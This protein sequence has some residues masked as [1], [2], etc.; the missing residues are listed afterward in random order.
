MRVYL[1]NRNYLLRKPK[2]KKPIISKNKI[3]INNTKTKQKDYNSEYS[4]LVY[5]H[6]AEVINQINF[7]NK[8]IAD[9]TKIYKNN[10]TLKNRLINSLK[11]ECNASL[12]KIKQKY[13]MLMQNLKN[14]Y[15]NAAIADAAATANAATAVVSNIKKAL[16]IGINYN[17]TQY[18]LN[19][20]INDVENIKTHILQKGFKESNI[21]TL[22][23]DTQEKPNRDTILIKFQQ[24]LSS[25]NSGDIVLF[26]YSGHGSYIKDINN[27]EK[28]NNDETIVP[29]DFN[30][31]SDDTLK[32]IIDA[33]LKEGVTLIAFFDSCHSGTMLDLP[34]QYFD[35]ENNNNNTVNNA[36]S[37]TK[38][39]V[40]MISGC[41]D[42]QTSADAYINNVSRGAMTWALLTVLNEN[43]NGISWADLLQKMRTN[44]INNK[45]TQMPQLSCG[46]RSFDVNNK[47]PF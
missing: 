22:T 17:N 7:Y 40:I 39:N 13:N 1:L 29:I 9:I 45:Y 6:N 3:K 47:T 32:S 10:P 15:N 28:D 20:C 8:K 35:S 33:N 4:M 43:S 27:E 36:N 25:S 34:Y 24:L 30:L 18:Q 37:E 21:T 14:K 19:G 44:L 11:A 31:I 16:L 23:D 26:T 41:R 46:K 5:M 38:G 42:S 12:L 2:T